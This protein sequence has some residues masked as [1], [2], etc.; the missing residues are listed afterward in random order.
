MS[1]SNA[2]L[3]QT[4]EKR[5]G[6]T[7]LKTE[8]RIQCGLQGQLPAIGK[9]SA[10][11]LTQLE[12]KLTDEVRRAAES[13][14][15]GEVELVH[16]GHGSFRVTS[17]QQ[18]AHHRTERK[19]RE[20]EISTLY[21]HS[22]SGLRLLPDEA[23]VFSGPAKNLFAKSVAAF[24]NTQLLEFDW[25]QFKD[26]ELLARS[27]G[28]AREKEAILIQ[29]LDNPVH[30]QLLELRIAS[31]ALRNARARRITAIVPYLPYSRQDR[32][33]GEASS[34]G[35]GIVADILKSGVDRV[36]TMDIHSAQTLGLYP[37]GGIENLKS[38]PV[39]LDYLREN[40]ATENLTIVSPDAG[41]MKRA[42]MFARTLEAPAAVIHKER[43][44]A[45]QVARMTLLG[46][47][48]DRVC[49]IVDDMVDTAGTLVKAAELLK[50]SGAK[51][52]IACCTHGLFSGDA[53]DRIER[54]ALDQVVTTDTIPLR[55]GEARKI[56]VLSVAPLFA[57]AIVEMF[58]N[59][60]VH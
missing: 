18:A 54:S 56:R 5:T 7:P 49:V 10:E 40:F 13:I 16:E 37:E 2:T 39:F 28:N 29:G 31:S 14:S 23:L 19:I 58:D 60:V 53:L 45:N 9:L 43:E 26:N 51:K 15:M 48:K 41:G 30:E 20:Q 32:L 38:A 35:A 46:E 57:D 1:I 47:V 34:F 8:L 55:P 17:S 44:V 24:C 42:E 36:V 50:K 27:S 21:N 33:E 59:D 6:E 52:V 12:K 25:R 11:E 4:A 3:L 22:L